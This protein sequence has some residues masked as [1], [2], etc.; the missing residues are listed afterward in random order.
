M[1]KFGTAILYNK[2]DELELF[3]YLYIIYK[4]INYFSEVNLDIKETLNF[5]STNYRTTRIKCPHCSA[6]YLAG[7]IF[8]PGSLIGQPTDVIKD[9][10]GKIVYEDYEPASKAPDMQESFI[11]E[12]CNKPFVVEA[13]VSYKS[14][15][16]APEKDFSSPYVSLI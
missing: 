3:I 2:I 11:C 6:E 8:M 12:Y 1:L 10:L 13:T 7:E 14:Y 4:Y 5:M 15:E 9:A 16:E